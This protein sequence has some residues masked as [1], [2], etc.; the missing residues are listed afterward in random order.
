MFA[1]VGLSLGLAPVEAA[2]GAADAGAAFFAASMDAFAVALAAADAL[3]RLVR[4]GA[5]RVD[6]DF[7]ALTGLVAL[8]A[9]FL[10]AD[11]LAV[12]ALLAAFAV[13]AARLVAAG[14]LADDLAALAGVVVLALAWLGLEAA[15][16]LAAAV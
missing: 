16:F 13:L 6:A 14:L 10:V 4:A 11:G 9:V 8:P 1:F 12:A 15:D 2:E 7:A 5:V 3:D